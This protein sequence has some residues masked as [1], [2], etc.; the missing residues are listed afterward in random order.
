LYHIAIDDEKFDIGRD[1]SLG[2]TIS[3]FSPSPHLDPRITGIHR[4]INRIEGSVL[5][6]RESHRVSQLSGLVLGLSLYSYRVR[7]L[8]VCL[9]FFTLFFAVLALLILG[10]VLAYYAAIYASHWARTRVPATAT[11]AL[12]SAEVHLE[13]IAGARQ[14]K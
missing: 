4:K 5:Q 8:V 2:R 12:A 6:F 9:L 11:L 13:T 3:L 1:E 7:E 14:L 10:G